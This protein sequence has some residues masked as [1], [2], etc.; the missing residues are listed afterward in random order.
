MQVNIEKD[1]KKYREL[2]LD[3]AAV[4]K[5]ITIAM[6]LRVISESLPRT[7]GLVPI[8][9]SRRVISQETASFHTNTYKET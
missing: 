7:S 4:R 1:E 9:C 5:Y 2:E 3:E 8:L 6:R